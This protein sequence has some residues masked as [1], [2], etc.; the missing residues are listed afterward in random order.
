MLI[1]SAP[2]TVLYFLNHFLANL[3]YTTLENIMFGYAFKNEGGIKPLL[4]LS[5]AK[6]RKIFESTKQNLIILHKVDR[7][8]KDRSHFLIKLSL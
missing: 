2:P 1:T 8:S 5:V 6:V 7:V 3:R 4:R